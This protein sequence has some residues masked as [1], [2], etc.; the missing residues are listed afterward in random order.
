MNG[1]SPDSRRKMIRWIAAKRSSSQRARFTDAGKRSGA[2]IP[3]RE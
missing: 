1:N 3:R 2:D